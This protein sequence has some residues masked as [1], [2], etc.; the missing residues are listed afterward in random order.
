MIFDEAPDR[1][2]DFDSGFDRRQSAASE[3]VRL[4]VDS[5]IARLATQ[6]K[7]SGVV[8]PA[9]TSDAAR[10]VPAA[11]NDARLPPNF[12]QPNTMANRPSIAT[13]QRATRTRR[14]PTM[15]AERNAGLRWQA[16]A[17]PEL[18]RPRPASGLMICSVDSDRACQAERPQWKTISRNQCTELS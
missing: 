14:Q 1:R 4:E 9:T 10:S 6:A 3:S 2:S 17:G 16:F 18:D 5:A 11:Q 12:G 15:S 8:G 13:L 7:P